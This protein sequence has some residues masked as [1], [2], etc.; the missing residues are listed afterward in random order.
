MKKF[1][2]ISKKF[3]VLLLLM[4]TFVFMI[5]QGKSSYAKFTV[6]VGKKEKTIEGRTDIDNLIEKNMDDYLNMSYKYFKNK[7]FKDKWT[8][9]GYKYE[10][11]FDHQKNDKKEEDI[12]RKIIGVVDVKFNTE[13]GKYDLYYD[14]KKTKNNYKYNAEL[15]YLIAK[16]TSDLQN[17]IG[18]YYNG[19]GYEARNYRNVAIVATVYELIKKKEITPN[20]S[21]I[22]VFS[23]NEYIKWAESG[24][25]ETMKGEGGRKFDPV[26]YRELRQEAQTY[27]QLVADFSPLTNKTKSTAK[28]TIE[29]TNEKTNVYKYGPLKVSY[30]GKN[31][32]DVKLL[33]NDKSVDATIKYQKVKNDDK[34]HTDLTKIPNNE[35]FYLQ[36]TTSADMLNNK[37]SIKIT[38]DSIDR[39]VARMLLCYGEKAIQQTGVIAGRKE[40]EPFIGELTFNIEKTPTGDLTI[41]KTD[42]K[43]KNVKLNAGFKIYVETDGQKGW[44]S[45]EGTTKSP[46]KYNNKVGN[47]KVYSTNNGTITLKNLQYGKYTVYEVKEP[48]G[49]K[50]SDQANYDTKNKWVKFTT[51][52]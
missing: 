30:G 37:S 35:E 32:K 2:T 14:G 21:F 16:R 25:N 24:S 51:K 33:V 18:L 13:T 36:I 11:C 40:A 12:T 41:N 48:D 23:E 5:Y 7:T 38:Q 6:P 39:Y 43:D 20:S 15:A 29:K 34:W 17:G 31:I 47:A 3:T 27:S 42:S 10:T 52:T 44:L 22:K 9:N 46:Y 26:K 19:I 8:A 28:L 50:K 49:Y 45:G 4:I 1:N